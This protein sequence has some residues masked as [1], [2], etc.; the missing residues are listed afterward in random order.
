MGTMLLTSDRIIIDNTIPTI[1]CVCLSV[2]CVV[3]CG[4]GG[5]GVWC[6]SG[7]CVC[8]GVCVSGVCVCV[9]GVCESLCVCLCGCMCVCMFVRVCVCVWCA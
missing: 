9:C 5:W 1:V 3:S 8:Q 6:V 2:E 4:R 7:V